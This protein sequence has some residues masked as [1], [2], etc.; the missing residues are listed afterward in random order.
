LP[1]AKGVLANR[2]PHR[3]QPDHSPLASAWFCTKRPLADR[4]HC[5]WTFSNLFNYFNML[6]LEEGMGFRGAEVQIL[7]SWPRFPRNLGR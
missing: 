7:S 3:W 1:T 2:W 6:C 4:W 5:Q